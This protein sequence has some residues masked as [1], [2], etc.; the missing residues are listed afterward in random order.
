MFKESEENYEIVPLFE[1]FNENSILKPYGYQYLF[2]CLATK[3]LKDTDQGI[4]VI[5]Q[6]KYAWVVVSMAFEIIKPIKED[7]PLKGTTWYAGSRG[8]FYRREYLIKDELDV[9]VKGSTYSVLLDLE[10][11]SIYRKR[12]LPFEELPITEKHLLDLKTRLNIDVE[13]DK[14]QKRVVYNSHLD[15]FGHVN[16][17]RYTEY[18]YDSLNKE[19]INNLEKVYKVE[20]F[21]HK[22]LQKNDEF[23]IKKA[24]QNNKLFFQID[25][26]VTNQKAFSLIL[27]YGN[28]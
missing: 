26:V 22:E 12:T 24:N 25:N 17:M 1:H 11:R 14:H 21:F 15:L 5:I 10:N 7:A 2:N 16:N 28:E 27:H 13:L 20:M 23:V 3:H 6:E 8:P 9:V 4:G 19:E 18:V